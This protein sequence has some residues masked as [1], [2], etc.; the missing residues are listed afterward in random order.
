[1]VDIILAD[2]SL[3]PRASVSDVTL[4]WASG[5]DE[6]D[7]ELTIADRS[8]TLARGWWW[9]I[10]GTEIGGRID[11]MR[12]TVTSGASEVTWLGRTWTGLLASKIIRPDSGQD[13]LTMSGKLPDVVGN[14]VRRIGLDSVLTVE[15]TDQSA[16]TGYVFKNPRY[17][18]A[19][20][21]LRELLASC[22]RRLDI[23]AKDNRI[24]LGIAPVETI[25][26]TVD[27]DLVDFKAETK[28]RTVN[29]LIG[30]GEEDL[31]NRYVSEW[32]ADQQGNV[33]RKQTLTGVDEITE[34]YDYSCAEQQT[35]DD[36]TM[37]RLQ[38]LQ[39]G[40]SVDVT[41]S[42]SIGERLRVDDVV[43]ASDHNTG[44]TVTAKVTKRI[45]KISDGIMTTS[46][47]VGQSVVRE[48]FSGR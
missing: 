41:L 17:V 23:N 40:G 2:A 20:T 46:C 16:V 48:T 6:N 34:I 7:F 26:N 19:Y 28:H 15:S 11:D 33:S 13:Y 1:M 4:D 37:K 3:T 45:I 42:E 39:T 5:T 14:L 12:T 21:G 25:G 31:K 24:L 44:L 38:E 35:L 10:D 36:N 9:W 32:Y 43:T 47:E 22:G 27:S 8:P 30:L 18:D 29:H